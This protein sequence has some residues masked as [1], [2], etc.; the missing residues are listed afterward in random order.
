MNSKKSA[1]FAPGQTNINRRGFLTV[2]STGLAF[3]LSGCSTSTTQTANPFRH[4]IASGD[5]LAD[6]VVIWTRVS[7]D[8]ERDS[9]DVAWQLSTEGRIV[10]EGSATTTAASD[11][12]IKVDVDGL[13]ERTDYTFQFEALGHQSPRGR[14][15]TLAT[16]SSEPVRLAVTS[17]SNWV[18]GFFNAYESIAAIDVDAVIHLGDY[19]YEYGNERAST[20]RRHVPD[21]EIVSLADYRARHAQYKTDPAAQRMH[22][23]HPMISVWDDHESANN[24]WRDGAQNHQNDEGSWADR[25]QAA[26]RAYFEWMPIR[27]LPETPDTRIFRRFRFGS[28]VDLHMLDTR[29]YGRVEQAPRGDTEAM[30]APGRTLLGAEQREWLTAG[31]ATHEGRWQVVGNQLMMGQLTYADRVVLNPD[32]WDGYPA[33]RRA[34]FDAAQAASIDKLIVV[35]G[36]IHSSWAVELS[37]DPFAVPLDRIG[38]ECITPSVTSPSARDASVRAERERR[39]IDELP[40]V[41]FVDQNHHGYLLLDI[42][43]ERAIAE[44]WFNPGVDSP[45]GEQYLAARYVTR[46]DKRL[47]RLPV[48]P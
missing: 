30:N 35:T 23:R 21:H 42:A 29:L 18:A 33:S 10:R 36:D 17:C 19:L 24:A 32:Q 11:W 5:P 38:V 15:R 44:W 7:T 12:T 27:G 40:H 22:A 45:S 26:I 39:L 25:K 47:E 8:V 46:G 34:I 28:V 2:G 6:R 3:G 1:P 14:A 37:R 13:T 9:I 43:E 48:E 16:R 4:G 41:A 20:E 31:L